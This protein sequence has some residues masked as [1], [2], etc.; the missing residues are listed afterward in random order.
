[1]TYFLPTNKYEEKGKDG[2]IIQ[3]HLK[4]WPMK[5]MQ[6]SYLDPSLWYLQKKWKFEQ[7]IYDVKE[8]VIISKHD[9]GTMTFVG[10]QK[11]NNPSFCAD[12]H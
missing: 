4:Y 9:N 12:S 2:L 11:E 10:L 1:M 5:L 7:W 8:S 3:R 6:G